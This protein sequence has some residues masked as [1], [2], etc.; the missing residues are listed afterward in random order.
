MLRHYDILMGSTHITMELIAT[1]V[2]C[3]E[4]GSS[5]RLS[6]QA[7][8][9]YVALSALQGQQQ[10][11]CECTFQ[12]VTAKGARLVAKKG[13]VVGAQTT[14]Q[15]LSKPKARRVRLSTK[16]TPNCWGRAMRAMEVT[17]RC[18][19][20]MALSPAKCALVCTGR[21]VLLHAKA[22]VGWH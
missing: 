12:G 9:R 22:S 18:Y 3:T 2:A 8:S 20:F 19:K 1:K 11:C 5:W 14:G 17:C 21:S 4:P 6:Q 7:A 15:H 16:Q 13:Q 10:P